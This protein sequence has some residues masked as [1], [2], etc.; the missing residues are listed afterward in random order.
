MPAYTDNTDSPITITQSIRTLRV[1]A[2]GEGG[3]GTSYSGSTATNGDDGA[4]T[5]FMGITAEGGSAGVNQTAGTGGGATATVGTIL[6]S[7]SGADGGS[8]ATI[9]GGVG[10]T[11]TSPS[12]GSITKG[13]GEDGVSGSVTTP[14]QCLNSSIIG[15]VDLSQSCAAGQ[16]DCGTAQAQFGPVRKCCIFQSASTTTYNGG[17]G[18]AGGFIEVQFSQSELTSYYGSQS[19]SV[20]SAGSGELN[21]FLE[22][23]YFFTEVYVKTSLG[24]Q[25]VKNIYV[26]QSE[27]GIGWTTS[28]ANLK[29][30]GW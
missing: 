20:N 29:N 4:D 10:H 19:Y 21:G 17:G 12:L 13:T 24:W 22:V 6:S 9:D 15:T 18:G 8:P 14:G 23:I 25:L 2:V 7:S 27:V 11:F 16:C 5:T 26:N 1:I 3:A 28:T 30:Y